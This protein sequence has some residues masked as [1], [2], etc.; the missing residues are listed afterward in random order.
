[1]QWLARGSATNPPRAP[2]VHSWRR[3][4]ACTPPWS[5]GARLCTAP[6]A[7]SPPL[8]AC[9]QTWCVG[10]AN[11][12]CQRATLQTYRVG[13]HGLCFQTTPSTHPLTPG[14]GRVQGN[15]KGNWPQKSIKFTKVNNFNFHIYPSFARICFTFFALVFNLVGVNSLRWC[16]LCTQPMSSTVCFW[17]QRKI[18]F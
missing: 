15:P 9:W 5:T 17:S 8:R 18:D 3:R 7:F 11:A 2:S 1:M 16:P 4:S 12:Q 14:G 13:R 6:L 10:N